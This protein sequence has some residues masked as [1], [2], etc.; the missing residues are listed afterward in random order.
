MKESRLPPKPIFE[1]TENGPRLANWEE[2]SKWCEKN[3]P[4]WHEAIS[5]ARK[6]EMGETAML[7]LL[8]VHL[9]ISLQLHY[10]ALLGKLTTTPNLPNIIEP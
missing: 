6:Q 8:C 3:I 2:F 7:R 4:A 9:A 10:H 5:L 1:D